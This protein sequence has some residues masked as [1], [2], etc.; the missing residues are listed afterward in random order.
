MRGFKTGKIHVLVAT[1]L[2]SRGI[3]VHVLELHVAGQIVGNADAVSGVNVQS[4]ALHV[5]G[6]QVDAGGID[7]RHARAGRHFQRRHRA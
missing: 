4:R 5:D 3:D 1:D 2:A 6:D 7:D